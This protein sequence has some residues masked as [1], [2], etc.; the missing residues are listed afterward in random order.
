MTTRRAERYRKTT[1]FVN[2]TI[3][4]TLYELFMRVCLESGLTKTEA[5]EEAIELLAD[6]YK[7][8]Q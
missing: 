3:L 5:V 8:K 4:Q 1:K 7:V 2:V 6:F